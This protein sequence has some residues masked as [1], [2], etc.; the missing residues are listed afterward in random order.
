MKSSFN[1]L[2]NK[3]D[4]NFSLLPS[5]S[6]GK[7][8]NF[9]ILLVD[10][11]ETWSASNLIETIVGYL[12]V[13]SLRWEVHSVP[14]KNLCV[15]QHF[16]TSSELQQ[17]RQIFEGNFTFWTWISSIETNFGMWRFSLGSLD[18]YQ[19]HSNQNFG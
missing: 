2:E 3:L 6:S 19:K 7:I 17:N 13:D 9:K 5:K 4:S 11:E 18:F 1:H 12:T 14:R 10:E 16:A 15:P 8:K